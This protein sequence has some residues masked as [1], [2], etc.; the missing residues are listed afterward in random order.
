MAKNIRRR[1]V[2]LSRRFL[3]DD[4]SAR[5]HAR[6]GMISPKLWPGPRQQLSGFADGKG[7]Y[8]IAQRMASP[9]CDPSGS[10]KMRSLEI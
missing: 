6:A 5:P 7:G 1:Q 8:F 2:R 9:A 3:P 10:S 4:E